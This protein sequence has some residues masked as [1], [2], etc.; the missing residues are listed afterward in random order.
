MNFKNLMS[1]VTKMEMIGKEKSPTILTAFGLAGLGLSVYGAY[2]AGIKIDKII[3]EKKGDL[4][5]VDPEDTEAKR[6]VT[7]EMVIGVVKEAAPV[8][9]MTFATG[10][11]ILGAHKISNKRIAVLS[12]AYAISEGK[13]KDLNAKNVEILGEKKARA[14][15]DAIVKDDLKK[16]DPGT[17]ERRNVYM[18]GHGD[19]L[20]MD[21][22]TGKEFYSS[23]NKIER[24]I[25]SLTSDVMVENYVSLN[26][27][28]EYLDIGFRPPMGDDFGWNIDDLTMGALPITISAQVTDDGLPILCLDYD[29]R[30]RA[31]YRNLH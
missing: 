17:V 2:K 13:L 25:N 6:E 27:L 5:D 16:K 7:K 31:D 18:T 20:C 1:F 8:V 15:K 28:F 9:I 22:Y 10:A 11:C 3:K 24:A 19:V 26:D 21:L 29:I 12:A 23:Y 4:K 14:I 30:P